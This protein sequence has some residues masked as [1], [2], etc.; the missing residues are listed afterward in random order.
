MQVVISRKGLAKSMTFPCLLEAVK[1]RALYLAISPDTA[2]QFE[3]IED[4][5]EIRNELV[6]GY[7]TSSSLYKQFEGTIALRNDE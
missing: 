2:I 6:N 1:G 4:Y 7:Y 3:A 5:Y